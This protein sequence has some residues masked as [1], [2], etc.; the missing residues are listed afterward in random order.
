MDAETARAQ[1]LTA[2][3]AIAAALESLADRPLTVVHAGASVQ[4][5]LDAAAPGATIAVEPG[6][7]DEAIMIRK[8]VTIVPL[9]DVPDVRSD[10]LGAVVFTSAADATVKVADALGVHLIGVGVTSRNN[11]G[12]LVDILYG[13]ED[14]SLDRCALAGDPVNGQ[15]RG[16]LVH[17]TRVRVTRCHV[18]KIGLVGRDSQCI[19]AWDGGLEVTV[20]DNY[21]EGGAETILLG[22]GTA[23][24]VSRIPSGWVITNSHLTRDP[25]TYIDRWQIKTPFELKMAQHVHLSDCVLEYAGVAEGQAAYL[26]VLTVRDQSKGRNPFACIKDVTIERV[27]AQHGGGGINF[28]GSDNNAPTDVLD[29][30]TVRHVKFADLK[31]TGPW[32]TGGAGRVVMFQRAPRNVTLEAIT[33][34]GTGLQALGYFEGPTKP[35]PT[36]LVLRNWKY[37]TTKYGWKIDA[38]SFD[39]PPANKNLAALV[40]DLTYAITA[41]DQGAVGYPQ[42]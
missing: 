4:A 15:H 14:V 29:G 41:S 26:L 32:G 40:P 37:P 19:A 3:A 33:A 10:G 7:Y 17:G 25:Q 16:I 20:D 38:G 6:I 13:A 39:L 27:L 1:L 18:S 31:P 35:Q 22:G 36:G 23:T 42:A 34:E 24:D 30:V 12:D 11:Q 28:L 9:G 2:Q 5:V 8:P 21:L